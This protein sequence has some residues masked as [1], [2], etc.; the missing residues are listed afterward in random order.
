MD[1]DYCVL[2]FD[3]TGPDP[4]LPVV[5]PAFEGSEERKDEKENSCSRDYELLN[6]KL[7]DAV[8]KKDLCLSSIRA[9]DSSLSQELAVL[10][11]SCHLHES[12]KSQ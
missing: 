8:S 7:N 2:R 1:M 10:I 4:I 3:T 11:K 9:S 12:Q 5:E 6:A